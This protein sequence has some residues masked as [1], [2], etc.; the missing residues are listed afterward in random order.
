MIAVRVETWWFECSLKNRP[1][2]G[3]KLIVVRGSSIETLWVMRVN[4]SKEFGLSRLDEERYDADLFNLAAQEAFPI[5]QGGKSV[6]RLPPEAKILL[7]TEVTRS[8]F[9]VEVS[10]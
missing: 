10:Y 5:K 3:D 8:G 2:K 1:S 7:V 4:A 9:Y 6:R